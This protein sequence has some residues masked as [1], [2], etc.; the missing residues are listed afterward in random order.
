[1]CF[2]LRLLEHAVGGTWLHYRMRA[3]AGGMAE[4]YMEPYTAP[5]AD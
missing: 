3:D 1:M 4:P 5:Y 2:I